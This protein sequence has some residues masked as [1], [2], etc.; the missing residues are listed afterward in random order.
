MHIVQNGRPRER[1]AQALQPLQGGLG[2]RAVFQ[3]HGEF[4]AANAANEVVWPCLGPQAL[5]KYPKELVRQG[6][7]P[8]LVEVLELVDVQQT[9][10]QDAIGFDAF[11]EGRIQL[12][13]KKAAAGQA[14]EGVVVAKLLQGLL[15][16]ALLGNI[17]THRDPFAHD[18]VRVLDAFDGDLRDKGFAVFAAPDQFAM[19]SAVSLD[20]LRDAAQECGFTPFIEAQD[21]R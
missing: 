10:G 8:L 6:L 4:I 7:P 1:L 21:G 2:V 12:L 16:A 17:L 11:L 20:G 3:C 14:G 19:P 13:G 9:Q 15:Q 5:R 18:A